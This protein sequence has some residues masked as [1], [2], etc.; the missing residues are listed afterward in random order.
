M[1]HGAKFLL[2]PSVGNF[3]SLQRSRMIFSFHSLRW[4]IICFI[5]LFYLLYTVSKQVSVF[6]MQFAIRFNKEC[7]F[8]KL[9]RKVRMV[10]LGWWRFG[11]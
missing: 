5:L 7:P 2:S 6:I 11:G 4:I 10:S 9:K 8:S 1:S 3:V